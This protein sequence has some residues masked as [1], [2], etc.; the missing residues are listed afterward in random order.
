MNPDQQAFLA[1]LGLQGWTITGTQP[2]T[3]RTQERDANDA[4]VTVEKPTGNTLWFVTDGRGHNRTI[5]IREV[6]GG[7]PSSTRVTYQQAGEV[8][9]IPAG[10]VAKGTS[11]VRVD[12]SRLILEEAVDDRGT[13]SVVTTQPLDTAKKSQ[14]ITTTKGVFYWDGNPSSAP[15]KLLDTGEE[16]PKE[17]ATRPN[18]VDGY[19]V[20][21]VYRGGSWVVD[22]AV[23]PRKFVPDNPK[24][25]TIVKDDQGNAYTWDTAAGTYKP[26]PGLPTARPKQPQLVQGGDGNWYQWDDTSN[27][28]AGGFVRSALPGAPPAVVTTSPDAPTIT[29]RDPATGALTAVPNPSYVPKDPRERVAQLQALATRE[30]DRL[31]TEVTEGRLDPRKGRDQFAAWWATNIEGPQQAARAAIAESVR[32]AQEGRKTAELNYED[33]R[34]ATGRAAGQQAEE[35]ARATLPYRVGPTFGQAFADA[36]AGKGGYDPSAVTFNMPNF[37]RIREQAVNAAIEQIKPFA[38][39]MAGISLP[40]MPQSFDLNAFLAGLPPVQGPAQAPVQA[41]VQP[42]PTIPVRSS[43]ARVRGPL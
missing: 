18:V 36:R 23:P 15:M 27:G 40:S 11:R 4:L 8:K 42:A 28:G 26:A 37:D 41:P 7:D 13:W 31:L 29:Q 12:G 19:A 17:G 1:Q 3:K 32:Q 38:D 14:T 10:T 21:Q 20:Q 30:R 6:G 16:K 34:Q 5:P 33:R 24:D 35:N 9:D 25:P 2:E 22:P 43:N 39:A